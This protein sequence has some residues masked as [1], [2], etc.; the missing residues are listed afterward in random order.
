MSAGL[1]FWIIMILGVLFGFRANWPLTANN[2]WGFGSNLILFILL[3]LLG[4]KV[5]GPALHQ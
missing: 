5:F 2:G 1:L 4:W 3:A